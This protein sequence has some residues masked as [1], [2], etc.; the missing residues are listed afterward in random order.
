MY[1][2]YAL[3]IRLLIVDDHPVVRAGLRTIQ[4][5]APEIQIVGE[6]AN[7]QDALT[8]ARVIRPHLVLLDIR[9]PGA[10][11][12]E[13]C[14]LIKARQPEIRVLFLTSHADEH[15]I[16]AALEAG[17][18]GYLMKENDTSRLISSIHEIMRGQAVFDPCV[19]RQLASR[20]AAVA[21]VTNPLAQL[22]AQ[23]RRLLSEVARGRTDK[24]VAAELGITPKTAR[25][26][27]DRIFNK[28]NVHNRTEAA[29]L[30]VRIE[31]Q[32]SACGKFEQVRPRNQCDLSA[33]IR[34]S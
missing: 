17:A 20:P 10:G 15:L 5:L 32:G 1:K 3:P 6:A 21:A 16:L 19:T 29:M 33:G 30:Y 2:E 4:E 18:D 22:T 12:I 24:E 11:G 23:E 13:V 26:Y 27:L 28:L 7:S 25:N 34:K 8:A 31:L 14:R 9:L